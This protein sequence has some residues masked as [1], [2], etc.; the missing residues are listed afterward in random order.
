M[1][2]TPEL[3]IDPDKKF[4]CRRVDDVGLTA[5]ATVPWRPIGKSHLLAAPW[6]K[7]IAEDEYIPAELSLQAMIVG[8]RKTK[9]FYRQ[10]DDAV[11]Y[12]VYRDLVDVLRPFV[13][14]AER[15][16]LSYD[17]ALRK[18]TP[19]TSPGYPYF[20]TCQTKSEALEKDPTGFEQ[21]AAKLMSG[22]FAGQFF[23]HVTEKD[24]LRLKEKV[25]AHKTRLFFSANMDLLILQA[26]L[27]S[28]LIERLQDT[29]GHHPFTIGLSMPGTPFVELKLSLKQFSDLEEDG[30][31]VNHDLLN[32]HPSLCRV[33]TFVL[34]HFLPGYEHLVWEL[35]QLV[36]C[37]YVTCLGGVYN[38]LG[39]KS[40][41]FLT[42]HWNGWI[43]YVSFLYAH[44]KVYPG[45]VFEQV[46]KFYINGDDLICAM[47]SGF[48]V[49]E[50]ARYL[51]N[52]MG[53]EY[54]LG[55]EAPVSMFDT[56]FL[57]HSLRER[58]VEALGQSIIIPA[59]NRS[60]LLCSMNYWKIT[61]G[62]THEES[63]LAHVMGLRMCLWPWFYDFEDVD[64]LIDDLLARMPMSPIV[65]MILKSRFS[66]REM[67]L[68]YSRSESSSSRRFFRMLEFDGQTWVLK[69]YLRPR[70]TSP[71]VEKSV[72]FTAFQS[73]MSKEPQAPALPPK[74]KVVVEVKKPRVV[75]SL[76]K[77]VVEV[78]RKDLA[79]FDWTALAAHAIA[80]V[81]AGGSLPQHLVRLATHVPTAAKYLHSVW[82]RVSDPTVEWAG[83]ALHPVWK[84][85]FTNRTLT[86]K[87]MSSKGKGKVVVVERKAKKTTSMGGGTRRPVPAS[88][89][90]VEVAP[91][92][93]GTTIRTKAPKVTRKADG[94]IIVV[95]RELVGSVQCNELF[96]LS[97]FYINPGLSPAGPGNAAGLFTWLPAIAKG[98]KFYQFKK[99]RWRYEMATGTDKAG[100]VR[101]AYIG[102]TISEEPDSATAFMQ[103][104][105]ATRGSAWEANT[106][107]M[108]LKDRSVPSARKITR[109]GEFSSAED[110]GL[111]LYDSGRFFFASD[112][113]TATASCGEIYAEY[114]VEFWE[115]VPSMAN[116]FAIGF[117]AGDS[118]SPWGATVGDREWI[119]ARGEVIGAVVPT[120]N[121]ARMF[122]KRSGWYLIFHSL[123]GG[124]PAA[125]SNVVFT[126]RVNGTDQV[127]FTTVRQIYTTAAIWT[128]G[129]FR[130]TQAVENDSQ[131]TSNT[132]AAYLALAVNGT[133][134]PSFVGDASFV[135]LGNDEPTLYTGSKPSKLDRSKT[136]TTTS[137]A[138]VARAI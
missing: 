64:L 100:T 21:R 17:E 115:I 7:F 137:A 74:K 4:Q 103:L 67:A 13:S 30:D 82:D 65:K 46:F 98:Y 61:E 112:G 122:F 5:L 134:I 38:V 48:S 85:L 26:R 22:D 84:D 106:L 31:G 9:I 72:V 44:K 127:L 49:H 126:V 71:F 62:M 86:P 10:L 41:Q 135:Y 11:L 110:E 20:Y 108:P 70:K 80:Q 3:D 111:Q 69:G 109:F 33:V 95:H 45:V 29:V 55:H 73:R 47:K 66:D 39:N 130:I 57:S 16:V 125:N 79:N 56:V 83:G 32:N 42:G 133:A 132:S 116:S 113:A 18:L 120:S 89:G 68:L 25:L 63:Q 104:E 35:S 52:E 40:G 51:K 23:F 81:Q 138:V 19:G 131:A 114:E 99:L 50:L 117:N 87:R 27:F 105:G 101:L 129:V 59:G 14:G 124:T 28:W 36:F 102:D 96:T 53:L 93:Y 123:V 60:K 12:D 92:A 2:S 136:I 107:D 15:N 34:M 6:R 37:G 43:T 97:T 90:R 58:Y 75:P 128:F 78:V 91:A 76:G 8:L 118:V 94:G 54:I 24:E 88:I 119:N 121:P 1:L 77:R